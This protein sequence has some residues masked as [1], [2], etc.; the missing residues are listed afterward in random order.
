[1]INQIHPFVFTFP[2][3]PL[4]DI[5]TISIIRGNQLHHF[6]LLLIYILALTLKIVIVPTILQF[7]QLEVMSHDWLAL[8]VNRNGGFFAFIRRRLEFYYCHFLYFAEFAH[9]EKRLRIVIIDYVLF[10]EMEG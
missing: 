4:I 10:V 7:L 2:L 8:R 5:L 1:M 9:S 3:H 6:F